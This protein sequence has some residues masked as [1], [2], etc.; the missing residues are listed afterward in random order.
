MVWESL[1]NIFQGYLT[2][3]ALST[4]FSC[5]LPFRPA[6]N[7]NKKRALL[8]IIPAVASCLLFIVVHGLT[9][10]IEI[11]YQPILNTFVSYPYQLFACV[12]LFQGSWLQKIWLSL[13]GYIG[14]VAVESVVILVLLPFWSVEVIEHSSTIISY[15]HVALQLVCALLIKYRVGTI[16]LLGSNRLF[17]LQCVVP[18]SSLLLMFVYS[19]LTIEHFQIMFNIA[20]MGFIS[21]VNFFVFISFLQQQKYFKE[22]YEKILLAADYQHREEYYRELE[23][24]QKEVRLI[25]HDLK[26]QL[27][28]VRDEKDMAELETIIQ[29]LDSKGRHFT[30]NIGL[31]QLLG[32]KMRRAEAGGIHCD[33]KVQVPGHIG[34][35]QVDIGAL[36]GNIMDNA[37]EACLHCI[38]AR[39]FSLELRYHKHTLIIRSQNSTD[40]TMITGVTKKP[41]KNNHGFGLFSINKTVEKY[42]GTMTW[43]IRNDLFVLDIL[44][45]EPK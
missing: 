17:A 39:I 30:E 12:L 23:E 35:S 2:A 11:T 22:T 40:G 32:A 38:G 3:L 21:V 26:N 7:T 4:F 14:M 44:L 6:W 41:D 9:E 34:F 13:I 10:H 37:I 1:E 27:L 36:V 28:A 45:W 20:L 29:T 43:E 24:H 8:L 19:V 33:F 31:N 42:N 25:R 15:A 18:V 16:E 5:F